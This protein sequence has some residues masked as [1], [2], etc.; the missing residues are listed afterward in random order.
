MMN[1]G[2]IKLLL[3]AAAENVYPIQ[4]AI[5]D[6]VKPEILRLYEV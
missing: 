1:F 2:R 4:V 5:C 3:F 6:W